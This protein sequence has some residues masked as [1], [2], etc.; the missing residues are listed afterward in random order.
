MKATAYA[1]E[2]KICICFMG[3]T[4]WSLNE[5]IAPFSLS[6]SIRHRGFLIFVVFMDMLMSLARRLRLSVLSRS[7]VLLALA[8][9]AVLLLLAV[10]TE[11]EGS[12]IASSTSPES[13]L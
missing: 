3:S 2:R 4:S 8:T 10:F 6:M 12:S 9:A 5:V 13:S 7:A 1:A 11:L